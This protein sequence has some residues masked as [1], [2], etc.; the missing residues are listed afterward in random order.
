MPEVRA[1]AA[2]ECRFGSGSAGWESFTAHVFALPK[3][4]FARFGATQVRTKGGTAR[5]V[6]QLHG[7]KMFVRRKVTTFG[8]HESEP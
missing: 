4:N 5:Y 2:V 1:A 8:C 7:H 6:A 3:V